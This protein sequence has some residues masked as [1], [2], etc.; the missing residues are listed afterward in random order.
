[1]AED[2]RNAPI[3]E[4]L[5]GAETGQAKGRAEELDGQAAERGFLAAEHETIYAPLYRMHERRV[6]R[7]AGRMVV[8]FRM[9]TPSLCR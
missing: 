6:V 9:P 8:G 3:L 2:D 4:E 7:D 5:F 1:M